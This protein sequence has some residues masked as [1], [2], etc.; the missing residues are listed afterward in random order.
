MPDLAVP[1]APPP[2][3]PPPRAEPPRLAVNVRQR[4]L[5]VAAFWAAILVG[6]PLWWTTTSLERRPLP[7]HRIQDWADSWSERIP[8]SSAAGDLAGASSCSSPCLCSS[9][10]ARTDMEVCPT[11]T[12]KADSRVVKYSPHIKLVFSLLNQD[13]AAD[14]AVLSWDAHELLSRAF[15]SLST[16]RPGTRAEADA[17]SLPRA[18]ATSARSSRPSRRSTTLRSRRRCSTLRRSPS[19]CTATRGTRERTSRSTTC[20]RSSTTPSGTS[21]RPAPSLSLSLELRA[22]PHC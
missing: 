20:A 13:S 2:P 11:R 7:G 8:S 18:Q 22:R 3:K 10:R 6:L 12:D 1:P 19:R 9:R 5:V 14:S 16:P 4:R 15:L 21:V 17:P